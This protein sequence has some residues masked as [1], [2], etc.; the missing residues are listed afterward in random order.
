MDL[1]PNMDEIIYERKDDE[2]EVSGISKKPIA[3][4]SQ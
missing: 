2:M 1:I 4:G 3:S